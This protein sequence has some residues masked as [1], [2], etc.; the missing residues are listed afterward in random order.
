MEIPMKGC[1]TDGLE[2]CHEESGSSV[3]LLGNLLLL[4]GRG[5]GQ[6]EAGRGRIKKA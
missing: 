6:Y 2:V 3:F 4:S 1:S 5:A